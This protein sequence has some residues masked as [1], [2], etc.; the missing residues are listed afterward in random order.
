MTRVLPALLV[1]LCIGLCGCAQSGGGAGTSVPRAAD[2]PSDYVVV[3]SVQANE[4]K[5]IQAGVNMQAGD[6]TLS[7]TFGIFFI[8]AMGDARP[9]HPGTTGSGLSVRDP[10]VFA[11]PV[12]PR[13]ELDTAAGW[14]KGRYPDGRASTAWLLR[15]PGD[16]ESATYLLLVHFATGA[17]GGAVYFDLTRWARETRKIG[18]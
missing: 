16:R 9:L 5:D 11:P 13:Q 7:A 2:P 4:G 15:S 10:I 8:G 3:G 12:E 14:L 18:S 6:P 1:A 17:G